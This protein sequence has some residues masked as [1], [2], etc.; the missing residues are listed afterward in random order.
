M[1]FCGLDL[2]PLP[3]EVLPKVF[4]SDGPLSSC[5]PVDSY[6]GD[7]EASGMTYQDT[8]PNVDILLSL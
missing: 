8:L 1:F 3:D 4:P 2:Q 6:M 5:E 7:R